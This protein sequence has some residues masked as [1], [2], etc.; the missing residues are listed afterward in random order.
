[1][2]IVTNAQFELEG[3]FAKTDIGKTHLSVRHEP[4]AR[5]VRVG[6]CLHDFNWENR[7]K[8]IETI[9]AFEDDH[10]D[11]FAVDFDVVPLDSVNDEHFAEA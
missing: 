11:D 8:A 9:L 6:A 10:R 4:G 7:M 2:A 5:I 3:R 1:M